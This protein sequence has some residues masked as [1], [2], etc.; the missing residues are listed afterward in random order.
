MTKSLVIRCALEDSPSIGI[1]GRSIAKRQQ[2]QTGNT[3]VVPVHD[4]VSF[5]SSLIV[6]KDGVDISS[7]SEHI[8]AQKLVEAANVAV[9]GSITGTAGERAYLELTLDH[10]N[11]SQSGN[12]TCKISG[13]DSVGHSVTASGSI[14]VRALTPTLDDVVSAMYANEI[15]QTADVAQVKADN[16]VDLAF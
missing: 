11:Q 7:V 9:K 8:P 13:I 15:Q 4:D 5:V 12:Y 14:D 16:K 1:V 2:S 6:L 10:P 3:I